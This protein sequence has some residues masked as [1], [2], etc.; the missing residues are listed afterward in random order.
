MKHSL[1]PDDR[2]FL[3]RFEACECPPGDFDHRGHVRL[4][5][6]YLVDRDAAAAAGVMRRSLVRFLKHHGITPAK[7]H[8]TM[9]RAWILA[10]RHFMEQAAPATSAAEFIAANPQL[11]D[12]RIML[13]HYSADLLFSDQ[14]RN[15][16][17]APDLNEIPRYDPGSE[18]FR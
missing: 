3:R 15:E 6:A 2:A 7:Y 13:T 9:T 10:V 16:F 17:V 5:Y 4:A 18:S 11:L 14:A 8:E 1:S 12:S